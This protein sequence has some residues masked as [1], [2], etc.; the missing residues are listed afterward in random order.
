MWLSISLSSEERSTK[1]LRSEKCQV[2]KPWSCLSL[3]FGAAECSFKAK[4][5]NCQ[6][7]EEWRGGE[8]TAVNC[9]DPPAAF[10]P[11]LLV[12]PDHHTLER[13]SGTG[14]PWFF[15][16]LQ[17]SI[18]VPIS[19]PKP[20]NL[21]AF[22]QSLYYRSLAFSHGHSF[23]T[24]PH[25]LYSH[26]T[27]TSAL[28]ER[29]DILLLFWFQLDWGS[30]V[31]EFTEFLLLVI[32]LPNTPES[33]STSRL[34]LLQFF[35]VRLFVRPLTLPFFLPWPEQT[36][37]ICFSSSLWPFHR[38]NNHQKEKST[39]SQSDYKN[40]RKQRETYPK[41]IKKGICP[42]GAD[43]AKQPVE[44]VEKPKWLE[45][46]TSYSPPLFQSTNKLQ[47]I[48]QSCVEMK[49]KRKWDGVER[50]TDL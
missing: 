33:H 6:D 50:K 26:S 28:P 44:T 8:S 47:R 27:P 31:P 39:V 45:T 17:R 18:S 3:P 32:Q 11:P 48:F 15:S 12:L 38:R 4:R 20:I 7:A 49:R 41:K 23:S 10:W 9:A 14:P 43:S 30:E 24:L 5:G 21:E 34:T 2:I 1:G 46:L 19:C 36:T 29:E 42:K 25:P 35:T 40:E 13:D 16:F 37:I 22:Q